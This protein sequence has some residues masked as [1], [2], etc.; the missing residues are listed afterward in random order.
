M[1]VLPAIGVIGRIG[2]EGSGFPQ[3]LTTA[4]QQ[5]A[6]AGRLLACTFDALIYVRTDSLENSVRDIDFQN[7]ERAFLQ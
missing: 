5:V 4:P 1:R 6:R 2:R 3:T 7:Q